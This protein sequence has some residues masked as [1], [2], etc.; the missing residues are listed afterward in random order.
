[1]KI[2][3]GRIPKYITASSPKGLQRLML[4]LQS[5]LGYGVNF[6]DIQFVKKEWIAWYYDND[7]ITLHNVEEK[8]GNTSDS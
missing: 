4:L 5:R 1:M 6:F 2:P 3:V 7:D 8:L